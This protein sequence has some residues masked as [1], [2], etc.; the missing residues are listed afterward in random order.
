MA[1]SRT[2]QRSRT[3]RSISRTASGRNRARPLVA[4]EPYSVKYLHERFPKSTQAEV[5][6]ALEECKDEI[7]TD[8]RR[9]I[10]SCLKQKLGPPRG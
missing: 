5:S 8:D 4:S 7:K 10:M 2:K 1:V 3:S 6:R 9:Q